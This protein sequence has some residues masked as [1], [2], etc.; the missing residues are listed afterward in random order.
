LTEK[1]YFKGE[2]SHIEEVRKKV[3]LPILRK[4]F[5]IEA[6]QIY[7]SCVAGADAILLISEILSKSQISEFLSLAK[8]LD[9]DCLVEATSETELNKI[10]K[11]EA[12]IIGINNRDLRSFKVD[13]EISKKLVPLIPGGKI[14]VS[15]SGI[16]EAD[17]L[18]SLKDLGVNAVLIG[19]ALLKAEDAAVKIRQLF[20][21]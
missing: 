16:K 21:I 5:I 19:E 6:Y 8:T 2:L 18:N 13:L 17:D 1:I 4:D 11:T 9:L 20:K 3:K 10:L 14:I 15:E 12:Q 7:E